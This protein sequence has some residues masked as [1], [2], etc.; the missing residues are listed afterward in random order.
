M[1]QTPQDGGL[2]LGTTGTSLIF[3]G[4][5]PALVTFLTLTRRDAAGT[6]VQKEPG[7]PNAASPRARRAQ[8]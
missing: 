3:L 5:I 6:V 8:A 1:S 4:T 7:P 2:G